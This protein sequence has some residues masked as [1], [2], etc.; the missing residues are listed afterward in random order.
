MKV[1]DVIYTG[2]FDEATQIL[3]SRTTPVRKLYRSMVVVYGGQ[4]LIPLG[5]HH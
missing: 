4:R 1:R 5:I 2:G 3:A